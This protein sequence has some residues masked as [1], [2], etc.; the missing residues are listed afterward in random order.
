M[1]T[2]IVGFEDLHWA[3][4][5]TWDLFEYLAR[6]LIDEQVVLVGTYRDNEVAGPP[7]HNGVGLARAV[8]TP[9]RSSNPPGRTGSRRD[10]SA[11]RD[12]AR[13]ARAERARRPGGRARPRQPLLHQ[14]ARRRAPVGRDHP[15]R[16]LRSDLRR[17][18]RSRRPRPPG[19]GRG[20]D[21][22]ARRRA[23][24]C[25]LAVVDLPEHEL[26]AAVRTVDRL[27]DADRR[28]RRLPLPPPAARRSRVRRPAAS[29][30]SP[31]A[32]QRRRSARSSRRPMRCD[33]R[34]EPVSWPSTSTVR[35]TSRR[36]SSALLAAADAAE[37]V[38]P[39]AAFAHLERAFE[40]WDSVERS[41]P[42]TSIEAH[43]L[44]QAAD[45]ATSTVGNER[46][47]QLARAAF[48]HG[49]PPLG[50]AWGHERLGRYLWATGR[51]QESRVEFAQAVA[52]LATTTFRRRPGLRRPRA[53]RADG[54]PLRGGRRLVREGLRPRPSA[55]RQ[56]CGVG[57]GAARAGHRAQ[58]PGR[59]G[60]RGRAVSSVGGRRS[61][62]AR[63]CARHGSICVSHSAMPATTRP[64]STP[65]STPSPRVS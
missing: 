42:P 27:T 6:N 13:C 40:L 47:V 65:P 26:E 36:P 51:L 58:Q 54:R 38:A 7:G 37:T 33:E 55:R 35:A 14:R 24:S 50:A 34:T 32:P 16:A 12:A 17:D 22:R 11:R 3:D 44:W 52:L 21:D 63:S 8:P 62:R 41:A 39:A 25:S 49:P 59:P 29:A 56:P 9:G 30:T 18:R 31:P 60:G 43:R 53:G 61:Q 48:E 64:R 28:Q 15:D 1:T 45:I 2:V 23:T 5:V 20:R 19:V 57:D 46:A 10:R 4:T